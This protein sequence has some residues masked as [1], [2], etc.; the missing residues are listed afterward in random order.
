MTIG[1]EEEDAAT[2]IGTVEGVHLHSV[3]VTNAVGLAD[4][5]TGAAIEVDAD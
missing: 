5:V 4:V 2:G 3:T 1:S